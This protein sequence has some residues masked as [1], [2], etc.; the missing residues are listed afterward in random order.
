M[1]P[2]RALIAVNRVLEATFDQ[3]RFVYEAYWDSEHEWMDIRIP[4]AARAHTVS[5]E[6]LGLDIAFAK[7]EPLRVEASVKFRRKQFE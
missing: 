1:R 7:G 3:R 2:R 5:T 4:S 6:G